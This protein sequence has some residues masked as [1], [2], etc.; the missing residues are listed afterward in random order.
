MSKEKK[1]CTCKHCGCGK[2]KKE[3]VK[4]VC[5]F[6]MEKV[7]V[8]ECQIQ[9]TGE[10]N[11]PVIMC[12]ECA[13]LFKGFYVIYC[14]NC[15]NVVAV[16]WD[17]VINKAREEYKPRLRALKEV[18]EKKGAEEVFVQVVYGCDACQSRSYLPKKK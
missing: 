13:E 4:F 1:E 17:Y 11:P 8:K 12:D 18:C 14:G 10:S 3:E 5:N 16:T 15:N 2:R 6:C 7:P 9:F